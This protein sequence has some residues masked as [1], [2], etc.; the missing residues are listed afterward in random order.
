MGS[1]IKDNKVLRFEKRLNLKA[2]KDYFINCMKYFTFLIF[3]LLTV[4]PE[5]KEK[6]KF[7]VYPFINLQGVSKKAAL[8]NTLITSEI[9]ENL[10]LDLIEKDNVSLEDIPDRLPSIKK[11]SRE[12][13]EKGA[14]YLIWGTVRA[15]GYKYY[16]NIYIIDTESENILY[17]FSL[18]C[19]KSNCTRKELYILNQKI[20]TFC[21]KHKISYKN[22]EI[23]SKLTGTPPGDKYLKSNDYKT[24]KKYL[25]LILPGSGQWLLGSERK[26][27][28]FSGLFLFTLN[29]YNAQK[30]IYSVEES[31]KARFL[32]GISLYAYTQNNPSY[33][34]IWVYGEKAEKAEKGWEYSA[35]NWL[36]IAACVYVYNV[37]DIFYISDDTNFSLN[38]QAPIRKHPAVFSIGIHHRF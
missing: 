33:G 34:A 17:D 29:I 9:L 36:F 15:S 25:S 38:I 10:S 12:A 4:S 30:Y 16:R 31:R 18:E 11:M 2:Y 32:K 5:A 14:N 20:K 7:M 35:N 27:Y 23:V 22:K 1:E 6:S 13:G 26:G 3:L 28:L 37:Y 8:N 19:S 24:H 21:D